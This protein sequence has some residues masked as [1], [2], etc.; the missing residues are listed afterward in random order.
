[1][2]EVSVA[3]VPELVVLVTVLEAE[4]VVDE[5]LVVFVVEFVNEFSSSYLAHTKKIN[6]RLGS[7]FFP[8]TLLTYSKNEDRLFFRAVHI[9]VEFE[10][11]PMINY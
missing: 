5:V 6:P 1:M 9:L 10:L 3:L 11:R 4:V 8:K 7:F 2:A